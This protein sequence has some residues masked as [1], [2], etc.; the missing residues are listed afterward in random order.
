MQ[1]LME[2][3]LLKSAGGAPG[4]G[5]LCPHPSK[6]TNFSFLCTL[7]VR[8]LNFNV[9]LALPC[10][11]NKCTFFDS[12]CNDC[13]YFIDQYPSLPPADAKLKHFFP[14][15][16]FPLPLFSDHFDPTTSLYRLHVLLYVNEIQAK[17]KSCQM[18]QCNNVLD[19]C[20]CS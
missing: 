7:P 14:L 19:Q 5:I 10:I 9:L 2:S 8:S 17:Q 3:C 12:F 4:T 20:R 18:S 13:T 11:L 16:L 15:I 1:K 6:F